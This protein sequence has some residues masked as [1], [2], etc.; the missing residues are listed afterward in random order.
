MLEH[1]LPDVTGPPRAAERGSVLSDLINI[2]AGVSAAVI[3]LAVFMTPTMGATR[4]ARLRLD[5]RKRQ[6][7]EAE[8]AAAAA[9]G[10]QEARRTLPPG[11]CHE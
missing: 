11:E 9:A 8:K 10:P 1:P 3:I 5:E 4:S 2:V 7:Y 6:M